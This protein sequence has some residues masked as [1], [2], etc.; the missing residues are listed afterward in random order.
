MTRA[1]LQ[2]L[3]AHYRADVE[4]LS[5]LTGRDLVRLWLDGE[6]ARSAAAGPRPPH[7]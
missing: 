1:D 3:R 5:E 2:R 6:A 4:A 7:G